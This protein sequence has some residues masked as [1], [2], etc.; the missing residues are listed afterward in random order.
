MLGSRFTAKLKN[1]YPWLVGSQA[2]IF[3][4]T[5]MSDVTWKIPL[6]MFMYLSRYVC[7]HVGMN[8]YINAYT[9]A[10]INLCVYECMGISVVIEY[11]QP[12]YLFIYKALYC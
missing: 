11:F 12:I 1:G 8:T 2:E 6:R 4:F 9:P 3:D 5:A 10:H 7:M